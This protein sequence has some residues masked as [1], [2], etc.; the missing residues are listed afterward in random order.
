MRIRGCEVRSLEWHS[1]KHSGPFLLSD[2]WFEKHCWD[3]NLRFCLLAQL[4]G[5]PHLPR[6]SRPACFSEKGEGQRHMSRPFSLSGV[7]RL[8][9]KCW[10]LEH[11]VVRGVHFVSAPALL[12]TLICGSGERGRKLGQCPAPWIWCTNHAKT[13]LCSLTERT[14]DT[15]SRSGVIGIRLHSDRW[16]SS[17]RPKEQVFL[18][19]NLHPSRLPSRLCLCWRLPAPYKGEDPDLP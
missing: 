7:R 9:G 1:H 10:L 13:S 3:N 8:G 4:W 19:V 16:S 6:L 18:T 14:I 12:R 15:G 17:P 11:L 2:W 5:H